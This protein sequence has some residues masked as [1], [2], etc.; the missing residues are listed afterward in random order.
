MNN[1]KLQNNALATFAQLCDPDQL[2]EL[3]P[4]LDL[5]A[6][7]PLNKVCTAFQNRFYERTGDDLVRNKVIHFLKDYLFNAE[8]KLNLDVIKAI[9]EID[10]KSAASILLNPDLLFSGPPNQYWVLR[11]I[12]QSNIP[13]STEQA[14]RLFSQELSEKESACVLCA[15]ATTLSDTQ[16]ETELF[17]LLDL[18]P[19][20]PKRFDRSSIM[21]SLADAVAIKLG[22]ASSYE[23]YNFQCDADEA[24]PLQLQ[25]CDLD[26]KYY[27]MSVDLN[28]QIVKHVLE[29]R[30][31]LAALSNAQ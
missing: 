9:A 27:E 8:Q 3:R 12:V 23:L 6:R 4:Y 10:Q 29:H 5:T 30:K 15:S 16:W 18:L 2:D 24:T 22:Y 28:T 11:Q 14:S 26:E 13:L 20:I 1:T 31:E 21:D 25:L 7:S 17:R 19:S